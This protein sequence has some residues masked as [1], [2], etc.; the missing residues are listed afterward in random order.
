[1][2]VLKLYNRASFQLEK[3]T[4]EYFTKEKKTKYDQIVRVLQ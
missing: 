3:S 1:M 2:I 4:T